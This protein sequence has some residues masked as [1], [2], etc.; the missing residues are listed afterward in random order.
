MRGR[1]ER[2]SKV[3]YL[4]GGDKQWGLDIRD[5]IGWVDA[6]RLFN[7]SSRSYW[8]KLRGKKLQHNFR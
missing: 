4:M 2:V 3:A 5:E 6:R 1:G 8:Q 7:A